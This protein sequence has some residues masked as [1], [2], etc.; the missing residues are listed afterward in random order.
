M[1]ILA[2]DL[3]AT[4]GFA[5]LTNTQFTFSG[6]W[7]LT[8]KR[9]ESVGMRYVRFKEQLDKLQRAEPIKMIYF[10]EVRNHAGV[11][12]AHQYGGYLAHLQA[13]C[14]E[15]EIEYQGVPVGEIKKAWTGRGTA[16]K[17][18]MIAEARR[19]GFDPATDDEADALAILVLKTESKCDD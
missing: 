10:E 9:M 5:L 1:S 3:G 12:A 7:S 11:V 18:E 13:W 15:H 17:D 14:V 19:R 8:S 4:T 2:L 6:T 16:K